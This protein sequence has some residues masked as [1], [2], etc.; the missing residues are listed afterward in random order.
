MKKFIICTLAIFI[1]WTI[2]DFLAHGLYLK[3]YYLQTADL[4]RPEAEAKMFLNAIVVLIG[5][6]LFT[7]IYLYLV[8]PKSIVRALVFGILMGTSA[9]I[10]MGYGFY[11]FSPVP[12]H[13]AMTWFLV[14]LGQGFIAGLVVGIV[15]KP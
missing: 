8:S 1:I 4:W 10:F 9:G 13:M 11:S 12:Y 7:L 6:A 5:S 2:I 3:E 15:A 14:K